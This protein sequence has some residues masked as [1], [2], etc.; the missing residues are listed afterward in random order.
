MGWNSWNLL[1]AAV[2]EENLRQTA[3]AMAE[4]GFRD[5]GYE[6]LVID[7]CWSLPGKRDSNGDLIPDPQK[8]P[9]G[10]NALTDYVHGLGFKMGIY[11]DAA[12]MTCARHPGSFGFEEQDAALWAAWGFDF[13]KYDYCH[14]PADQ[15]TAIERYSRMSA[16]LQKTGRPFLYSLCEWGGRAPHT[17]GRRVGGQMWRVS[18]DVFDAWVN[19]WVAE[20]NFYGIGVDTSIDI[21]ASVA[22]YGGPGGW[23][24]LDMLIVGLKGRGHIPGSGLTFLEYQTHMSIWCMACSPLM[25][26]CDVRSMDKD[27]AALLLNREV[28]AVNQ[29]ALGIPARRVLQNGRCEIWRKPLADGSLAVALINRGSTGADI[30]LRACDVGLLDTPKLVRDLW[31]GADIADFTASLTQHVHPHQTVL[32][33]IKD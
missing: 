29:D 8:F 1:G 24:D 23:N 4:L 21:A 3:K 2:S 9:N 6:Y 18:G 33:K 25:I 17:W 14:A 15:A 30:V 10:M 5:Y 27:T 12:E 28:L 32:L 13:L 7:D 20:Y 16:A 19:L 11:S 31:Q 22:D 26:G